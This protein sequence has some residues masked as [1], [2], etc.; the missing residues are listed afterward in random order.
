[1]SNPKVVIWAVSRKKKTRVGLALCLRPAGETHFYEWIVN[2]CAC[3]Q[4]LGGWNQNW[5]FC[6]VASVLCVVTK[7]TGTQLVSVL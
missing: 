7:D 5:L 4:T 2:E 1:M 6:R 3:W